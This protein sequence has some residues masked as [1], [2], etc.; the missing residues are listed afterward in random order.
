MCNNFKVVFTPH[1]ED[2]SQPVGWCGTRDE[3]MRLIR[4]HL[5]LI[6]TD[7][8]DTGISMQRSSGG[9]REFEV[10]VYRKGTDRITGSLGYYT[11]IERD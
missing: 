2:L 8:V 6:N 3:V 4:S 5:D 7:R 9:E 1:G 11:Q 10:L